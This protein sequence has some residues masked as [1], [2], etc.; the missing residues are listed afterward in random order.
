MLINIDEI[1]YIEW[2]FN[3]LCYRFKDSHF[4]INKAKNIL[5][6]IKS[7]NLH[8]EDKELEKIIAKYYQDFYLEK[9]LNIGFTEQER[10]ELRLFVKNLFKDIFETMF[11]NNTTLTLE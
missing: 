7:P 3:R 2:V 1:I 8:I 5:K 11:N 10:K 4:D 9:E 6:K